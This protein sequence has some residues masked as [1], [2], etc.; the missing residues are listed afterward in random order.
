MRSRYAA[1]ARGLA[2]Y[3][4]QTLHPSRRAPDELPRVRQGLRHVRW[5]GLIVLAVEGGSILETTG[6]VA[7]EARFVAGGRDEVMRERSRFVR[8]QGVWYYVDGEPQP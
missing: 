2:A 4:V 5:T 1:H 3:L 7:F 6:V 8:E